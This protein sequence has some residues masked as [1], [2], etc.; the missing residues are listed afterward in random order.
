MKEGKEL[1][2]GYYLGSIPES[3][4]W[5]LLGHCHH[6]AESQTRQG[7]PKCLNA[8]KRPLIYLPGTLRD[9]QVGWLQVVNDQVLSICSSGIGNVS[10]MMGVANLAGLV[11][12]NLVLESYLRTTS[13]SCPVARGTDK[14]MVGNKQ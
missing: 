5:H 2:N 8:R 9:W 14:H 7:V 13:K 4:C 10:L 3:L 6:V 11:A 12:R 1:C